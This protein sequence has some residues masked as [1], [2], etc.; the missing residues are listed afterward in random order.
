MLAICVEHN[1]NRIATVN[2]GGF[3]VLAVHV[4]GSRDREEFATLDFSGGRYGADNKVSLI[5]VSEL[6]LNAGDVVSVSLSPPVPVS[7]QGRTLA[8]L[9]PE[10]DWDGEFV[11]PDIDEAM[12]EVEARPRFHDAFCFS[13]DSSSGKRYAG[14]TRP[15]ESHFALTVLWNHVEPDQAHMSLSSNSLENV[16]RREGGRKQAYERMTVGSS[17]SFRLIAS[18]LNIN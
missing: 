17:V 5:W 4:S 14:T 15:P 6:V 7:D 10:E 2:T 16:R 18:A 1:G 13:L 3:E 9:F 12:H 11:M 8:E